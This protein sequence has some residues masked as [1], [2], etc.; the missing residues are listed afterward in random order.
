[1][2]FVAYGALAGSFLL[3]VEIQCGLV[4]L[5]YDAMQMVLLV[6]RALRSHSEA[7]RTL[8][9]QKHYGESIQHGGT[10]CATTTIEKTIQRVLG[11]ACSHPA[12]KGVPQK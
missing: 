2:V 3:S 11:N 10:R 8:P 9:C 4:Y 1:M 5:N 12:A 7:Q 6:P